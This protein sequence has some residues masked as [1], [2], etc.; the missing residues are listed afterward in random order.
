MTRPWRAALL[1]AAIVLVH[2]PASADCD[3]GIT[4]DECVKYPGCQCEYEVKTCKNG[5]WYTHYYPVLPCPN[6]P[7]TPDGDAG[8]ITDGGLSP[9]PD[10]D[11][12]AMRDWL[13]QQRRLLA[14][15]EDQGTIAKAQSEGW[16]VMRYHDQVWRNAHP[17]VTPT[18]DV[19]SRMI[20]GTNPKTCEIVQAIRKIPGCRK[21]KETGL[22]DASCR[23]TY[24]HEAIH[25]KRCR[26]GVS[27]SDPDPQSASN[28][29]IPAYQNDIDETE[30]YLH[31]N[32]GD[33]FQ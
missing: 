23:I 28:E 17:G 8:P 4:E 10:H 9:A 25:A 31:D 5:G 1:T 19:W 6:A 20:M 21:L 3:D 12:R 29:E 15:Y 13:E 30:K 18:G 2:R 24:D 27:K 14:A 32:C 26:D 11:C 22:P 16:P 33:D 7:K